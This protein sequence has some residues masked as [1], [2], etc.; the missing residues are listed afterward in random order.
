MA[1]EAGQVPNRVRDE[2]REGDPS[3][4]G[5]V[6]DKAFISSDTRGDTGYA[7][8]SVAPGGYAVIHDLAY[9]GDDPYAVLKMLRGCAKYLKSQGFREIRANVMV[10]APNV[11]AT[12]VN[13]GFEA[14][15]V[16]FKGVLNGS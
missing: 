15:Q 6:A 5:L 14:E 11:M 3:E 9:W 7:A 4:V 16:I 1:E 8:C 13:L 12:L 2:I 10:D